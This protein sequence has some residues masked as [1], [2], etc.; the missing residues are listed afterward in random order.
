MEELEA[1][2]SRLNALELIQ[3]TAMSEA[4]EATSSNLDKKEEGRKRTEEY[5]K[6]RSEFRKTQKAFFA[7]ISDPK[8]R[9]RASAKSFMD[10]I[11][12]KHLGNPNVEFCA[13][14]WLLK[15]A[16]LCSK[17]KKLSTRHRYINWLHYKETWRTTNTGT[18]LPQSCDNAK[19]LIHGKE[20]DDLELERTLTEESANTVFLYPSP[21]SISVRPLLHSHFS[22]QSYP[23]RVF[24]P[25]A[26]T[27]TCVQSFTKVPRIL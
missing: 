13:T 12:Q 14:C 25:K 11:A 22:I 10:E 21:T 17:L 2:K 7:S 5:L 16:C 20:E 1:D 18:L 15:R 9:F 23:N 6:T 8:A 3:R 19:L 27:L 24:Y 4:Q 26:M